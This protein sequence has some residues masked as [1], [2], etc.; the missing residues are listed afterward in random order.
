MTVVIRLS[1]FLVL[2]VAALHSQPADLVL[3]YGKIVTMQSSAP[4]VEALAARGGKIVAIGTNQ[5]IQSYIGPDTKIV[6]LRGGWPSPD[7]SKDTAISWVSAR[8]RCRSICAT[9]RIGTRL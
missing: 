4:E 8:R 6:N 5:Q 2:S 9:P 3:R 1:V 7:S